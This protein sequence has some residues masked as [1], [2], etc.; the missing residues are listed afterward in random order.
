ME[1]MTDILKWLD[2]Q[3]TAMVEL[4]RKWSDINTHGSNPAGISQ[5]S[6]EITRSFSVFGEEV[7]PVEL[8]SYE[9]INEKG[10]AESF[11]VVPALTL[12]KRPVAPKQV[13]F[14]CHMDTVH[15][16]DGPFQTCQTM[17]EY[18]IKG[19]GITD[20]KGGI[21]VMLKALEAV[22]QCAFRE[23]FGWKVI[24]NTD[25]EIGSP[26]SG[27]MLMKEAAQFDLGLVF[28]PSLPNGDL[29]SQRKGSGNFT[30]VVKG[31]SAHAGR[32]PQEGR[33]AIEALAL[34]I[35][36]V[37]DIFSNKDDFTVNVGK[38][39]GGTAANVV[40]DF[41]MAHLNV[42]YNSPDMQTL[43]DREIDKITGAVESERDVQIDIYG[44][45][46]APP[47]PFDKNT[48]GLFGLVKECARELQFDLNWTKSGGVCDGN[49]LAAAALP[50]IDTLGV[51]GGNIHSNDEYVLTDSFTQ[52]A[53]LTALF[54]S[55][56]INK[57]K[58]L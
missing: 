45:F 39:H 20:A 6:K 8:P 19:P 50:T 26:S 15:M 35:T 21:V 18:T 30:V 1:K 41:A 43:F 13:L 31:K 36:R 12:T 24:I 10:E 42:R 9:M 52:R 44:K 5:L 25:E 48:E 34:W 54:L 46:S 2:G 55:R 58:R 28:E 17:D 29:V 33:N 11:G 38:M 7:R 51:Q 3:K 14:V 22:E 37:K 56:W 32:N 49:R 53:K 4:A 47:K 40:A 27:G 16:P 23:K 57:D